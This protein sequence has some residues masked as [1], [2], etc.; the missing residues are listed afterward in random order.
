MST[1][2]LPAAANAARP[3]ANAGESSDLVTMKIADQM[4]GIPVLQVNDVLSPQKIT[5]IP[6]TPPEIAGSLNLRGRI[7]TVI[8][9]RSRLGL[10]QLD[11]KLERMSIV[12]DHHGELY[13]LLIDQVGEVMSLSNADFEPNPPT[14]DKRWREVALGIYRL[15]QSLLVV[16]D[17]A[18]LLDFVNTDDAV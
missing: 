18:R 2:N 15:Q 8:D 4:F 11:A 3:L 6:L 16:L 1:A 17:V 7:V 9:V 13:S 14:L 5:R 10:P 12:V